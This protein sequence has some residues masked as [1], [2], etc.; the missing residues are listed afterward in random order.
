MQNR[1]SFTDRLKSSA[2]ELRQTKSIALCGALIALYLVLDLFGVKTLDNQVSLSF[3]AF[4][5]LGYYFGPVTATLAAIPADLLS[6]FTQGQTP[7]FGFTISAM[8][9]C[10]V[11]AIFFYR[12][13]VKLWRI[14][15][16]RIVINIGINSFLNALWLKMMFSKGYLV[17]FTG[18]ITKNLMLLPFEIVLLWLILKAMQK[19]KL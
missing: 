14:I 5:L 15:A 19:I 12:Q 9:T 13:E 3:L 6:V 7:F 16:A 8:L 4:A 18:H 10:L 1:I 2:G 17:Y 11:F